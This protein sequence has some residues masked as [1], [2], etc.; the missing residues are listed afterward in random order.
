MINKQLRIDAQRLVKQI[1][2]GQA[3]AGDISHGIATQLFQA[4]GDTEPNAPEIFQGTVTPEKFPVSLLIQFRDTDA[5]LIRRDVLGYDV[6]GNLRQVHIG[7]YAGGGGNPGVVKHIPDHGHGELM[8][9]HAVGFQV[10]GDIHEAFVHRI[11]MN[12]LIADIFHV[13]GKDFGTDPLI[14]LHPGPG[15]N[16]I[17]LQ[18]RIC[19]QLPRIGG[20]PGKTVFPVRPANRFAQ[21]DGAAQPFRIDLFNP[22]DNLEQA[23]AAGD[24]VS[25]EAGRNGETDGFLCPGSVRHNKVNGKRVKTAVRALHGSVEAFEVDGDKCV[26]HNGWLKVGIST[27]D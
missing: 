17:Q 22:L 10:A 3:Q 12:I 21:T 7:S 15:N 16:I 11:D 18:G 4:G 20:A 26:I 23:G 14:K 13:D 19:R 1:F 6:H 24:P 9:G 25:L 8:G 5:V 2:I 27:S